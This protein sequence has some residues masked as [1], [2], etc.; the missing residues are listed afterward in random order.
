[1]ERNLRNGIIASP[2]K[3]TAALVTEAEVAKKSRLGVG[4]V[5]QGNSVRRKIG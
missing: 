1:V 4:G 2:E 5:L 3:A